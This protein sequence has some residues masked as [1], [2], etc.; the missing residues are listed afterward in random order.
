M[1]KEE[2]TALMFQGFQAFQGLLN[3][4]Q[5]VKRVVNNKYSQGPGESGLLLQRVTYYSQY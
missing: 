2:S 5:L 4:L 3:T 1:P